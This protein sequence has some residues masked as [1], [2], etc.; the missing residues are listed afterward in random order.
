ML[1]IFLQTHDSD[2]QNQLYQTDNCWE[3]TRSS[4]KKIKKAATKHTKKEV[5]SSSWLLFEKT[6]RLQTSCNSV[7]LYV[8]WRRGWTPNVSSTP[9]FSGLKNCSFGGSCNFDRNK[10]LTFSGKCGLKCEFEPLTLLLFWKKPAFVW[11]FTRNCS[12]A[13]TIFVG[14]REAKLWKTMLW[15]YHKVQVTSNYIEA[16]S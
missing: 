7:T 10:G 14:Q 9:T 3:K 12:N 2:S 11:L 4:K 5:V 1:A 8:G 13:Y 15:N 6:S 16:V